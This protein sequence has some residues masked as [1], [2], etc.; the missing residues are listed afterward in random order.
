METSQTTL[1]PRSEIAAEHTWNKPS[2]FAD[3]AAWEAACQDLLA[4]LPELQSYQGRLS[5]GPAVLADF[6]DKADAV[7]RLVGKIYVYASMSSAVDAN[8]QEATAMEG[9][10]IGFYGQAMATIAFANPELI[11]IGQDTLN[12]WAEDEPR[13]AITRQYI[14]DLFRQ[15]AHVRSAEVE[16][17][18]GMAIDPFSTVDNIFEML[19]NADMKFPDAVGKDGATHIV[20]Q[21]TLGTLLTNPDR[22]V[23]RTAWEGYRDT[24]LA[25][26]NTLAT[27]YLTSVKQDVFNMRVRGFN[28][29]LEASLFNNNIPVN[30][31]QN[32]IDTFKRN[33]P[34]WHKYWDVRRRALG[35]DDLHPYDIWAPIAKEK[36][37]IPYEQSVDWISEG[38]KPLGDEYVA[39]LRKGCLENR[40]VDIYPSQGKRAG[41]FS[42]GWYDTHP[43]IMMSYDGTIGGMSTLAH[44]LG[45]SMH[46]YLSRKK[47]PY[48]YANYSLFVAE[49]ASNFNQALTRAYL[50]EAYADDTNFQIVMIEE[51]MDNFHRYFFI[52][53]TLARFEL[54]IHERVEKGQGVTADDMIELMTDLFS[55]GYGSEVQIHR[56]RVGIT[57]ATFSHLYSGF[58]VYQ[59][60]TG[61]SA[62]HALAKNILNGSDSGAV[63]RYVD[64]LSAGS[65]MYALD[66]LK[67]AGVDMTQPDA[68]ETTFGV[69]ADMVDRLEQLTGV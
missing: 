8:D 61:I 3:K 38:M 52:M 14:D 45:H 12:R 57:W 25:L 5:E 58:Y 1:P 51:A 21:G 49:V 39:A 28:S 54:E 19:T 16:Q 53:P 65:S 27:T 56:Q 35:Q 29:S 17:I 13:L 4:Q 68:V 24:Y 22:E 64:F 36:K 9:Q 46:S 7:Q 40:W 62:A 60:A 44:E 47:Q 48:L 59:Y 50:R 2:V 69:L 33:I 20:A 30:V 43:F 11:A 41:A 18:L 15:Q 31:F 42:D 67:H 32:L 10:A 37:E 66:A 6:L 34:T 55:E 63:Q 23:R 26:K